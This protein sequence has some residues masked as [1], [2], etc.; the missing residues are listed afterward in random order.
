MMMMM[1]V[2]C[3]RERGV[4]WSSSMCQRLVDSRV[5]KDVVTF[6]HKAFITKSL[7]EI[8]WKLTISFANE[9]GNEGFV[10]ASHPAHVCGMFVIFF[11]FDCLISKENFLCVFLM[12]VF[13]CLLW[14]MSGCSLCFPSLTRTISLM[15]TS[16]WLPGRNVTHKPPHG[17]IGF[18]GNLNK[19]MTA[20]VAFPCCLMETN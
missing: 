8:I 14:R 7:S 3:E 5:T 15:A 10:I 12:W 19:V 18:R 11:S 13:S 20:W 1:M 4:R 16:A 6:A 2:L 9:N 17:W